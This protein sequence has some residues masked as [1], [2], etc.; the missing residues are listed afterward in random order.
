MSAFS[1]PPASSVGEVELSNGVKHLVEGYSFLICLVS[2]L[3]SHD[4]FLDLVLLL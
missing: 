1:M 3:L 4:S 2:Y